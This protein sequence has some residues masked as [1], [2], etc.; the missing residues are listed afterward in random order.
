M[1]DHATL[2]Q[3]VRRAN[4]V[5]ATETPPIVALAGGVSGDVFCV[6]LASGPIC[7]K[8]PVEKLRVAADWHA[9][10]ERAHSE[11]MWLRF[12]ASIDRDCAPEVLFEDRTAHIFAMQYLPPE[13]YPGWK[14]MLM[15]GQVDSAFAGKV[16][17]T[18]AAIHAASAGRDD[19]ATGFA[20][21]DLFFA[22]RIEPYLLHTAKA[23]ADFAPHIQ[24]LAAGLRASRI[25][26]MHGDVSPKNIL[27]GPAGP[28]FLDA[29]TACY[30]DPVFDLAFCLNHLLLKGVYRRETASEYGQSF[31]ALCGSYFSGV[32][33]EDPSELDRRTARLLAV[34]LLAR[35]DGKSP[36]EYLTSDRDK[37]FV[38]EAARG[39]MARADLTLGAIAQSWQEKL[40]A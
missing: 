15:A 7:V 36:V 10:L 40:K 37:S 34:L 13:R 19:L 3:A 1:D 31:D 16:G 14:A 38:R 33:W 32:N 2:L 39:F 25:A 24:T 26:L 30:G 20:N 21:Q 22:L 11:V 27:C 23:H 29:E 28:V 9:P 4:L 35:I 17:H 8:Q 6:D 5:G 18:L 12:A